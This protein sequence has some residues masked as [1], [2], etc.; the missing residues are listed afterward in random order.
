MSQ[1]ESSCES[2]NRLAVRF[3]YQYFTANN[4][5]EMF[6]DDLNDGSE[7]VNYPIIIQS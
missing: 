5:A 4:Y 3:T 1:T 6:C 7:K 2:T